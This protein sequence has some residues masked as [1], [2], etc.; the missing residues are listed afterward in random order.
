MAAEIIIPA[1]LRLDWIKQVA[2]SGVSHIALRVAVIISTHINN[3]TGVTFIGLATIA[4]KT[5]ASRRRVWVG[6]KELMDDGHLGIE[7]GRGRG[8]ANVY[9]MILKGA[10]VAPFSDPEKVQNRARKSGAGC[11]PTH[12]NINSSTDTH[13]KP[14]VAARPQE[15]S[16]DQD[17]ASPVIRAGS[18]EWHEL[19]AWH[20]ERGEHKIADLLAARRDS[21][22]GLV[23]PPPG[24]QSANKIAV[25]RRR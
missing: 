20:R 10:P 18:P 12:K 5:R 21:G 3:K 4:E 17:S 6:V 7:K 23:T 19:V 1:R 2:L 8:N 24:F 9:R 16:R 15:A 22:S 13:R 14:S 11:T 25:L